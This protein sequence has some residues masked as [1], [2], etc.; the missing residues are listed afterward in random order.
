[1]PNIVKI[2]L[3]V[4]ETQLQNGK[5]TS[6]LEVNFRQDSVRLHFET[7]DAYAQASIELRGS[8]VVVVIR[9]TITGAHIITAYD[10]A[11]PQQL[12]QADADPRLAVD[13]VIDEE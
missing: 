10:F 11:A 9:G 7:E 1:M 2:P 12:H 3:Q 5:I 8:K 4:V 13:P 6:P